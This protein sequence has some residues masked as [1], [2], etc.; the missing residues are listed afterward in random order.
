M[1]VFFCDFFFFFGR[2]KEKMFIFR[3]KEFPKA[4]LSLFLFLFIL[5]GQEFGHIEHVPAYSVT[6]H[7]LE[8]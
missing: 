7:P 5:E 2:L 3:N 4:L 1:F 8:A 6:K